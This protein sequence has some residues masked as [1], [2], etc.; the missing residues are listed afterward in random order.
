MSVHFTHGDIFQAD[1]TVIVCPTNTVGVMGAGLAKAFRNRF[2][3]LLDAYRVACQSGEHTTERAWLWTAPNG[4]VV[5]CVASKLHWR[6]PA[7]IEYVQAGLESLRDQLNGCS[8][9]LPR[10]GAGLG[11]LHWPDVR[12]VILDVFLGHDGNV[13]ILE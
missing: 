5:A 6:D 3:G 11:G 9:A 12:Q 4:Q 2:P 8:V 7:R 1:T 13:M 10:I